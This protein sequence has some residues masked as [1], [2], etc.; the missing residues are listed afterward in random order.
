MPLTWPS[1]FQNKLTS[2]FKILYILFLYSDVWFDYFNYLYY[3]GWVSTSETR[4]TFLNVYSALANPQSN[5][6][7]NILIHI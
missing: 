4:H 1:Q 3:G 5:I 2:I 6:S 7:E